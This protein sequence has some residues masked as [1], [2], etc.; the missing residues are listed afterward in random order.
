MAK[1][2]LDVSIED[3]ERTGRD[4]AEADAHKHDT[5]F[6]DWT[7]GVKRALFIVCGFFVFQQ[8]TGINV[9]LY[10]GPK[11]LGSLFQNG[12]STVA[13]TIAGVEVTAIMTVV[14]VAA[15]YFAFRYIDRAGR[16]PLA[17]GG[18]AG[19]A[20]FALV[21]AVGLTMFGGDLRIAIVMVGLCLFIASFAIGVGGTGWL[22]QGE[23]FPTAVRGQAASIGATVDWV[24]NFAIIEIFPTL[25]SGIGLAWVLVLFA[26]MAVT[27][28]VFVLRYL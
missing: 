14:N 11:L 28:V 27:A 16:R 12:H 5:R 6:R 25:Q 15:T 3:V 10:Y 13:A 17:I 8:I 26:V 18:F 20:T 2:G 9:P 19:M 22:I 24:A 23:M 4:L 7:P 1:L 21:S